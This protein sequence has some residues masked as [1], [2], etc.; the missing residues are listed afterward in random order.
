M[1]EYLMV[2]GLLGY[3]K[4]VIEYISLGYM[5]AGALANE[6]ENVVE[7]RSTIATEKSC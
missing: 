2:G 5:R 1:I 6:L 3:C 4:T 7:A